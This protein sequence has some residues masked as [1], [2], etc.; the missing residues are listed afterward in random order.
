WDT[1]IARL[2]EREVLAV[3]GHEMG[4]YVHGDVVRS[5]LLGSIVVL[6]G[7]FFVD[8]VG[9]RLVARFSNRL[10]F[11]R[12][13]DVASVPL[14]LMLIEVAWLFLAPAA[15][16]YSR[17]QEHRADVYSLEVTHDPHAAATAFVKMQY[18]NLSNPRPG[19][20]YRFF[21]ASHPSIGER[22]DY[23]N[24]HNIRRDDPA[25]AGVSAA[26]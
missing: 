14:V 22:I 8:R 17:Y 21:R 15:L 24:S 19:P 5:I 13:S 2:D 7:L 11:D 9:R 23:F 4:H 6:P 20:I 12:L 16:A 1:L 18:E 25:S 10:G 26:P 3:M